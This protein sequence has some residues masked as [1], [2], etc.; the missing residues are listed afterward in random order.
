MATI[1][2]IIKRER[3]ALLGDL[4]GALALVVML[5]GGLIAA[6]AYQ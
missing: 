3:W 5:W 6:A 1:I 4:I 2:E